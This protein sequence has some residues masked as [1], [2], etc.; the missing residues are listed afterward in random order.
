[1]P[2]KTFA[3]PAG[4]A[5]ID[6][7]HSY[8]GTWATRPSAKAARISAGRQHCD[9][10]VIDRR[11][12]QWPAVGDPAR[13]SGRVGRQRHPEGDWSDCRPA[14]YAPDNHSLIRRWQ[15]T[16]RQWSPLGRV[17]LP[18]RHLIWGYRE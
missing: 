9:S 3:V 14:R 5:A 1:L 2:I 8:H 13:R 16:T 10:K 11:A 17:G 7:V 15:K 18:D 6:S 12:A 4:A